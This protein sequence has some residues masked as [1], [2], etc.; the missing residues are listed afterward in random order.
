MYLHKT[1]PL[2]PFS[3]KFNLV[4]GPFKEPIFLLTNGGGGEEPHLSP[5]LPHMVAKR[6]VH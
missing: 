2:I 4:R 6:L 5:R 3:E 1:Y